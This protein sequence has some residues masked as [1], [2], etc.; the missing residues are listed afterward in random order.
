[1]ISQVIRISVK[2][3]TAAIP[4]NRKKASNMNKLGLT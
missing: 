2:K 3:H 1:M 4:K